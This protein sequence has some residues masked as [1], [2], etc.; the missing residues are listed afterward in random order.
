MR[1]LLKVRPWLLDHFLVEN[2]NFKGEIQNDKVTYMEEDK[3]D[4]KVKP[5]SSEITK[6]VC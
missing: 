5:Q 4:A 3:L 2:I 1:L 6:A